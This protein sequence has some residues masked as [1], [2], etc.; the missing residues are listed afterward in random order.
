MAHMLQSK[1]CLMQRKGKEQAER[2]VQEG[3]H[4]HLP[5]E[6]IGE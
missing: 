3:I 2:K 1:K 5:E 4:D 6:F